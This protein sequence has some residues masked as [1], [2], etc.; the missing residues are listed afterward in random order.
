MG[1]GWLVYCLGRIPPPGLEPGGGLQSR[2]DP[3]RLE[4]KDFGS[5]VF[6]GFRCTSV[7]LSG[8]TTGDLE[9]RGDGADDDAV[10]VPEIEINPND[11]LVSLVQ[12]V[13]ETIFDHLPLSA[14]GQGLEGTKWV[15][16]SGELGQ[17]AQV[18]EGLLA[19]VVC[20]DRVDLQ[21]EGSGFFGHGSSWL[22]FSLV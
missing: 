2:L 18:V 10:G 16:V 14:S 17:A 12:D 19:D 20:G 7:R 8:R 21:F 3:L 22:W 6:V 13:T 15:G 11:R 1:S 4:E 9:D 5:A